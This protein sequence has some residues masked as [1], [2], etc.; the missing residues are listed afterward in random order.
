MEGEGVDG[1]QGGGAGSDPPAEGVRDG[2]GEGGW[3]DPTHALGA[4]ELGI[5]QLSL[6]GASG[7][8]DD[9]VPRWNPARVSHR[10]PQMVP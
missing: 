1:I 2:E 10:Q 8:E 6:F 7:S 9:G 3:G 5:V 4:V